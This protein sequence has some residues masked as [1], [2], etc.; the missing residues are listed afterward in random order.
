[1]ILLGG[2]M[3]LHNK[4]TGMSRHVIQ[5]TST[6]ASDYKAYKVIKLAKLIR[7]VCCLVIVVSRQDR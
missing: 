4:M 3:Q 6:V 2:Q 1:M 5:A 7:S